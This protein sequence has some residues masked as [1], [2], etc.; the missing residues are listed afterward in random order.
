[1]KTVGIPLKQF[2]KELSEEVLRASVYWVF[3]S[4]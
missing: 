3:I 2:H 4:P 1:M